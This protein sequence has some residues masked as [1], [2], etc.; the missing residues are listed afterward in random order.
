RA[1]DGDRDA[2]ADLGPAR[3][4]TPADHALFHGGAELV[5]P[6][7]WEADLVQLAGRRE[8]VLPLDQTH[9]DPL[10]ARRHHQ[11][12]LRALVGV[13]PGRW[14]LAQDLAL[15]DLVVGLLRHLA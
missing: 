6:V 4:L 3:P 15:L 8:R 13:G 1:D 5:A 10:P 14:V 12:H 11:V 2:L 7:D 9:L